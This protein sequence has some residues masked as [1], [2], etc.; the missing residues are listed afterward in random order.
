MAEAA[1]RIDVID[2]A[3]PF[4]RDEMALRFDVE[5]VCERVE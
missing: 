5:F 2:T 4:T 1:R 3:P